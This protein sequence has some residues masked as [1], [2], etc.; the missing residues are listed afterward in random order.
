MY[1]QFWQGKPYCKDHVKDK[2]IDIRI[3]LKWILQN[4]IA[5]YSDP[6]YIPMGVT[7]LLV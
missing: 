6:K 1:I 2:G 4:E 5:N 7:N 3:A